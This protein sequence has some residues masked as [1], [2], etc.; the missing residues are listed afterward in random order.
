M[1][2]IGAGP[3]LGSGAH[4]EVT[5]AQPVTRVAPVAA[6]A[7][8]SAAAA[9]SPAAIATATA[10]AVA[11]SAGATVGTGGAPVDQDRVTSIRKAIQHGTYP[12][13][14]TKIG[15]A[16]IAAGVILRSPR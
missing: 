7:V 3:G 15:D 10:T 6:T 9:A 14:P 16:M 8:A 2:S 5:P 1:S 4:F 13:V 11:T 12:L